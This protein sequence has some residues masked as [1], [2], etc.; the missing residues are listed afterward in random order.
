V[1]EAS[2]PAMIDLAIRNIEKRLLHTFYPCELRL[3]CNG[4][5]IAVF[6]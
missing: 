5:S 6:R 3:C 1:F 4:M 2:F